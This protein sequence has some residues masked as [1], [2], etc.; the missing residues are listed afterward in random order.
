M[1]YL[2]SAVMAILVLRIGG[3]DYHVYTYDASG[4]VRYSNG[5]PAAGM[6]IL[7]DGPM[8]N[9]S[10]ERSVRPSEPDSFRASAD[11][12]QRHTVT[13]DGMGRFRDA[14]FIAG[15]L[16]PGYKDPGPAPELPEV[17][18]WTFQDG[19][20]ISHTVE[21]N[22][23]SQKDTYRAGRHI[24]VPPLTL[25]IPP[26]RPVSTHDAH[27]GDVAITSPSTL[28]SALNR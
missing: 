27:E 7:M 8:W 5:R 23:S 2:Q 19:H 1:Q 18:L 14:Y 15:P 17:Y 13:T 10:G 12:I 21:V 28:G 4:A 26:T 3:C 20:W 9:P 22:T 24:D 11:Y 25:A 16:F 6:N